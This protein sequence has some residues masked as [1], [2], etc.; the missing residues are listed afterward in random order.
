MAEARYLATRT[1]LSVGLAL[2]WRVPI[3][4]WQMAHLRF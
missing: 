1:G 3:S 2:Y 4:D